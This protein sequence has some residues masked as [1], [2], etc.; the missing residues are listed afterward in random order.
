MPRWCKAAGAGLCFL[1]LL[2]P[3]AFAADPNKV[4]HVGFEIEETGFDPCLVSD[5]YSATGE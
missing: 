4:L 3:P 1:L 2:C 5:L